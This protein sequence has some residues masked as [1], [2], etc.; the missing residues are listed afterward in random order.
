VNYSSDFADDQ[1][2]VTLVHHAQI[3]PLLKPNS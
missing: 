1:I 2:P 3:L